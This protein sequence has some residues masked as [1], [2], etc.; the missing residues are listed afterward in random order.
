ML[1]FH[2]LSQMLRMYPIYLK[3]LF[4]KKIPI[5]LQ[6]LKAIVTEITE[7]QSRKFLITIFTA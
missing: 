6:V 4:S 5:K 3:H 2:L 7:K 1:L